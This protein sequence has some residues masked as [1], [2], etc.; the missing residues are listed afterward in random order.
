[1]MKQKFII[2]WNPTISWSESCDISGRVDS[3]QQI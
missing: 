3:A 1:M 2:E